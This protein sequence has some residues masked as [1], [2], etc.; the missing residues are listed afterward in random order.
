MSLGVL[1]H[2]WLPLLGGSYDQV[3][4]APSSIFFSKPSRGR[5]GYR[6]IRLDRAC[7]G[8]PPLDAP[9]TVAGESG[10][11]AGHGHLHLWRSISNRNLP[12]LGAGQEGM[13]QWQTRFRALRI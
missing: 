5:S 7:P 12:S 3:S 6:K 1:D 11:N 4:L 9:R 8:Y 10:H 2:D 13:I